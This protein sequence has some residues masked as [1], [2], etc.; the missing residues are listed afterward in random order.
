MIDFLFSTVQSWYSIKGRRAAC[1]PQSTLQA[2]VT[3]QPVYL[4]SAR[5][6]LAACHHRRV[7]ACSCH[8]P[9]PRS[10]VAPSN[11]APFTEQSSCCSNSRVKPSRVR[12]LLAVNFQAVL[13]SISRTH[14]AT[15]YGAAVAADPE[16]A[17]PVQHHSEG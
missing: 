9:R 11:S 5:V 14:W 16:A 13:T 6:Q 8:P 7:A 4:P 10:C 1:G 3:L 17:V 12:T 2:L 15:S